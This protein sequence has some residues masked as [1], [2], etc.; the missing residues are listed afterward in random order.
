LGARANSIGRNFLIAFAG[1]IASNLQGLIALPIIIRLAGPASYGAYVLLLS[2]IAFLF[3][4]IATAVPYSYQRQLPSASNYAQRRRLFEPQFL[5]QLLL[6]A[7]LAGGLVLAVPAV[8]DRLLGGTAHVAPWLLVSL[9]LANFLHRQVVDYFQYTQSYRR[10]SF[11]TGASPYVFVAML[12]IVSGAGLSLSLDTLLTLHL[13]TTLSVMAPLL[14]LMLREIGFPRLRLP[15][16]RLMADVRVGVPLAFEVV[17]DYVLSFSDRYLIALFLS[18]SDVGRYQPAYALASVVLFLPRL[19][20]TVL[21]PAVSQMID[22]GGRAEAERAVALLLQLF[23][24]LAVPFAVGALMIGP[25]LISLLTTPEIS[26]ASRWV[27]PLV[28]FGLVFYGIVRIASLVAFVLGR[29]DAILG[30]L[31]VGACLNLVLN[32]VFLP[33]LRDISVP[34]ATIL[35]G[36]AANALCLTLALRPLWRLQL[37]WIAVLRYVAAATAMAGPLLFLG[38]RPAASALPDALSLMGA[39]V[40]AVVTYFA[41]LAALGGFGRDEILEFSK[42]MQREASIPQ[43][44]NNQPAP[45]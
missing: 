27:T 10:W 21:L 18:I 22:A 38:Y 35:V 5:F 31:L 14:V 43:E 32:L 2:M 11:A 37:K 33:L 41:A 40:A 30:G 45:R 20:E 24:M 12:L 19:G 7:V 34:A 39:V 23:L 13:V 15:L 8:D 1:Q 42:L 28:A 6:V 17:I 26:A 25:P 44:L 36:Y 16:R 29:T 9:L 3:G 4:I